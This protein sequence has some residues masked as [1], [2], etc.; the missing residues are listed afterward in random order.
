M[1]VIGIVL[2]PFLFYWLCD[3][4]GYDFTFT[5]YLILVV[6]MVI[7]SALVIWES[8]LVPRSDDPPREPKTPYPPA[9]AIV[10]AYLPNEQGVIVETLKNLL[11][12]DYPADFQLILAYNTPVSLPVEEE[13]RAMAQKE[14]RLTVLRVAGSLSKAQNVAAALKEAR[15]EF[16]G[17]FDADH[18]P[19]PDVFTRAWRW[20]AEGWDVVQGRCVISNAENTIVTRTCAVD[21]ETMYGINHPGR[22]VFHQFAI[23][24]GSNGYWK[25]DVLKEIR[26][27]PLMLTEDID[28]TMRALAKGYTFK[29]DAALI[30]EELAPETFRGFWK[31]RIR[32]AQGWFQITLKRTWEAIRSPHLTTRQKWGVAQLLPWNNIY[33]LLSLQIFPLFFWWIFAYGL[34]HVMHLI[35]IFVVTTIFTFSAGPFLAVRTYLFATPKIKRHKW[36]FVIYFFFS[37]IVFAEM[38]NLIVRIAQL[39]ECMGETTWNITPRSRRE[40]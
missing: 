24:G 34:E 31:Q 20:L 36:W 9:T 19:V 27:S 35:P 7:Q 33:A 8:M 38:K 29:M 39:K 32:W 23:F 4:L 26:F 21:F 5:L 6:I 25:T 30:S 14:T 17:I 10:C 18:R 15:G 1:G 3:A 28:A 22:A 37:F 2:I 13:L 40:S 11:K 16:V 12:V